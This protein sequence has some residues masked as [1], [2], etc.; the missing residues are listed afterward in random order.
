M[1]SL[2]ILEINNYKVFYFV[3]IDYRRYRQILAS[4]SSQSLL[5]LPSNNCNY[6]LPLFVVAVIFI[7]SSL[8]SQLF[9]LLQA[10]RRS[11]F[12]CFQLIFSGCNLA[13]IAF[14]GYK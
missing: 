11:R 3:I 13:F 7:A 9:L 4:L 6:N 8:S 10:C 5:Y 1:E 14:S 12:Y 2:L